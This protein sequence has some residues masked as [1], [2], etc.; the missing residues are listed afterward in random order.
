QACNLRHGSN[1][2]G[3]PPRCS[4]CPAGKRR[5]GCCF[6]GRGCETLFRRRGKSWRA[7][8]FQ[9]TIL[10][11]ANEPT[12]VQT[13]RDL[14]H[15]EFDVRGSL[16]TREAL[17]ILRR[18]DVHGVMADYRLTGTTGVTFLRQVS[19]EYPAVVGLVFSSQ[20]D[21]WVASAVASQ[22]AVFRYVNRPWDADDLLPL[23]RQAVEQYE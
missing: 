4:Y 18:Q 10:V 1:N 11:V 13:L 8:S 6:V 19:R 16:S 3:R 2:H 17:A 22:D 9:P 21:T 7:M 5:V 12:V 14:I 15:P 23:L 20:S